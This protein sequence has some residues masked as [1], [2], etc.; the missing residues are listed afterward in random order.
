ME[1]TQ[2]DHAEARSLD[3]FAYVWSVNES[4]TIVVSSPGFG[5]ASAQ[6]KDKPLG[7][8]DLPSSNASFSGLD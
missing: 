6:V 7:T 5:W 8:D 1:L 3:E 2:P 4:Q